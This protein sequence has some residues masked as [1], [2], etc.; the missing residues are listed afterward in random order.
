MATTASGIVV[1]AVLD[2]FDPQGD[3]VDLATSLRSQIT[4]PVPNTAARTALV[5]AVGWVPSAAEP[6][7]VW[8]ADAL[9]GRQH[10]YTIDGGTS[11]QVMPSMAWKSYTPTVGGFAVGTGGSAKSETIWRYEGGHVRLRFAFVF[12]TSGATFPTL[13]NFSLPVPAAPLQHPYVIAGVADYFDSSATAVYHASPL[14]PDT[15]SCQ[16]FHSAGAYIATAGTTPTTPFVWA[17]GDAMCG[18]LSYLPAT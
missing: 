7:H 1:P 17:P 3:M 15:A 16:L 14:L 4:I 13:P 18:E 12:G 6:L 11:W 9:P 8:R 5:A 2:A 10:E